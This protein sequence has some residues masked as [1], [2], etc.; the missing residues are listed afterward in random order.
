MTHTHRVARRS[1]AAIAL[2]ATLTACGGAA[3][4]EAIPTTVAPLKPS[5]APQTSTS[6]SA[7]TSAA[8]SSSRAASAAPQASAAP[9]FA[10]DSSRE[11]SAIPTAEPTHSS[12]DTSYLDS[13]AGDG[14]TTTGVENQL[15]GIAQDICLAK[16]NGTTSYLVEGFAGQLKEQ[17]LTDLEP[18]R[19]AEIITNAATRA[20]CP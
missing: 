12:E 13:V 10:Q 14:I 2:I 3:E 6:A 4:E 5:D 11:I 18:P 7:S 20:Y 1:I 9:T 17:N 19:A 15:I 8:P 16:S